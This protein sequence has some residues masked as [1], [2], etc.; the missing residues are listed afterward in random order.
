M[1]IKLKTLLPIILNFE[2]LSK[3]TIYRIMKLKLSGIGYIRGV[4]SVRLAKIFDKSSLLKIKRLV[5]H[6]NGIYKKI[7]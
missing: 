6:R 1:L 7:K 5:D 4:V 2:V 3:A